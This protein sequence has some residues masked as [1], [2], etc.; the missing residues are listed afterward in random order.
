MYMFLLILKNATKLGELVH[1]PP[2]FFRMQ[3]Y[4]KTRGYIIASLTSKNVTFS[5]L[6]MESMTFDEF[7]IIIRSLTM[8][9]QTALK[10]TT[11]RHIII[12]KGL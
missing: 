11:S 7:T 8:S 6:Q 2:F 5:S 4:N 10:S 12:I 9:S 1:Y 3:L